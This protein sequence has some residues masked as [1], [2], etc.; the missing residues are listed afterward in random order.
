[1]EAYHTVESHERDERLR[2]VNAERALNYY[3][4]MNQKPGMYMSRKRLFKALGVVCVFTLALG[5]IG[6]RLITW[7]VDVLIAAFGR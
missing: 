3:A 5:L 2:Q 4:Y 6:Y 1:M 7:V